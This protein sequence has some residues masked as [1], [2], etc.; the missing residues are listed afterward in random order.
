MAKR[1]RETLRE[2]VIKQLNY[3]FCKKINVQFASDFDGAVVSKGT[4]EA[5]NSFNN[6]REQVFATQWYNDT[7]WFFIRIRFV[8]DNKRKLRLFASVSF[9]QDAGGEL[10]QLFRAEWDSYP[11]TE[12]SHHPQPH[13]H[14]TAQLSDKT[15]FSELD[16]GIDDG[17]FSA[18]AG[19][20]K[21][22]NLDRMHF[23]MAGQWP[24]D[25][26]MVNIIEGEEALVD[27]LIH[28]FRHVR[29]ELEYKDRT[30]G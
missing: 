16:D 9:F 6:N 14:F 24:N 28:L 8:P 26:N 19:N 30:K 20:S 17:I 1:A 18:L 13:W 15:S 25:G 23:A 12:D 2:L 21:T 7:Y 11:P 3:R 22:I 29:E 10:K 27:W 5:I 4:R